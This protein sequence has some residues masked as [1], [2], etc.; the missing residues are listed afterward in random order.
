VLESRDEREQLWYQLSKQSV[1]AT[2]LQF[3]IGLASSGPWV[4]DDDAGQDAY[5]AEW[6]WFQPVAPAPGVPTRAYLFYQQGLSFSTLA[7]N[8]PPPADAGALSYVCELRGPDA[9]M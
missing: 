3:W 2:P 6:A 8:T 1:T 4:W 5:P 9:G 7:V